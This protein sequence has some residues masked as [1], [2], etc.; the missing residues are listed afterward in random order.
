M[1]TINHNDFIPGLVIRIHPDYGHPSSL[2]PSKELV[3]NNRPEPYVL[4]RDIGI[5]DT[6]DERILTWTDCFQESIVEEYEDFDRR[7]LWRPEVN[8]FDWYDEGYRIVF[9]LR[10]QFPDVQILPQFAHYVFSVNE[11]RESVGRPPISLPGERKSGY[12]SI[13]EIVNRNAD[14]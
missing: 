9:E 1:K 5:D 6:L 10:S 7:P 12:M 11:R 4:P 14:I 3:I 2:W 8:A 13:R